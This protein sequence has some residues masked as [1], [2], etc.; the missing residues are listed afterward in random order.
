[1][2]LP[3]KDKSPAGLR[4][5]SLGIKGITSSTQ[6][7]LPEKSS[8]WIRVPNKSNP[9]YSSMEE[10]RVITVERTKEG[11]RKIPSMGPPKTQ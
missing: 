5:S 8:E 2:G 4:V 6:E 11:W 10:G 7:Q 1:M 9:T 3:A